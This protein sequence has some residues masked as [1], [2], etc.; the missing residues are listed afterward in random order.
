MA[1]LQA[2]S[3]KMDLMLANQRRLEERLLVFEERG[4]TNDAEKSTQ[5]TQVAAPEVVL[6]RR[7]RAPMTLA[8]AWFEW[9]AGSPRT[10]ESRNATRAALY[11]HRY[12]IAY[13]VIFMPFCLKLDPAS[14]AFKNDVVQAGDATQSE[15]LDFLAAHGSSASSLVLVVKVLRAL[16]K[17]GRLDN[18]LERHRARLLSGDIAEPTPKTA[19]SSFVSARTR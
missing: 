8:A 15:L 19:W 5:D 1:Q 6:K 3:S 10:Y 14:S 7:N 12:A 11:E 9:F 16:H 18:V 13:M 2:M 17:T 4:G